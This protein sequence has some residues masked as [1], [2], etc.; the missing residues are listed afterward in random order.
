MKNSKGLSF[1]FILI[2]LVWNTDLIA[3][4]NSVW[5][6]KA[7]KWFKTQEWLNGKNVGE[8]QREYDSFGREIFESQIDSDSIKITDNEYLQLKPHRSINNEEF[9][10]QYHTDKL[11]WDKAFAFLKE[12]VSLQ[13]NQVNTS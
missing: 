3:Q 12:N 5:S 1:L 7:A 8:T 9:A 2:L 10:N 13:L 11:W 6:K 4:S